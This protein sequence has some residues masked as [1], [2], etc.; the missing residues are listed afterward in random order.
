MI[1]LFK[2]DSSLHEHERLSVEIERLFYVSL[3]PYNEHDKKV[4]RSAC[5][6]KMSW[7]MIEDSV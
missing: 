6:K 2:M 3:F 7:K 5:V 4:S 1:L